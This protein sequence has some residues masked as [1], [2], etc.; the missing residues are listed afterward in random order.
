M[1]HVLAADCISCREDCRGAHLTT[2]TRCIKNKQMPTETTT[3]AQPLAQINKHRSIAHSYTVHDISKLRLSHAK[4][5][6]SA[7]QPP[8]IP[9]LMT[10]NHPLLPSACR[11]RAN[12]AGA[13][14]SSQ[15][16]GPELLRATR[17]VE[18]STIFAN[19][20]AGTPPPR[21]PSLMT[22]NKLLL[23]S[24]CRQRGN[25]AGAADSSQRIGP[26]LLRATRIVER[27]DHFRESTRRHSA[28]SN[29]ITYDVE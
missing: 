2:H 23:P 25:S 21:I 24:A 16:I 22:S 13:A 3:N 27:G 6:P 28:T 5:R 8:P 12:S 4:N 7:T 9:S 26:E 11:Q 20:P 15:R 10:S 14:D 1:A 18:R 29:P 19:R 17:I